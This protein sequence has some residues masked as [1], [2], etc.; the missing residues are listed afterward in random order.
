[1]PPRAIAVRPY[2]PDTPIRLATLRLRYPK[3][4]AETGPCGLWPRDIG[5]SFGSADSEN[6]PY[7]NFGCAYQRNLAAN[8]EDPA[9][10]VQP[11]AETPA[12]AARRSTVLEKYRK[13]EDPTTNY[14]TTNQGRISEIGEQ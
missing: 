14:R 9:D 13:G 12:Y 8:V 1:V 4:V 11:R 3:M 6:W 2:Q 5:A 10:L 7:W